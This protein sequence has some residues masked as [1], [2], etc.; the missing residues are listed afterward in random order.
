[1][2]SDRWKKAAGVRG[3]R[4]RHVVLG[5]MFPL[6]FSLALPSA[7]HAQ[8]LI[9][10]LLGDR[11]SNDRFQLG[12]NVGF[13]ATGLQGVQSKFRVGFGVSMYG[14]IRLSDRFRLQPELAMKLPG[15]AREL[16]PG[17]P[18]HSLSPIGEPTYDDVVN[19]GLV[20]RNQKYIGIPIYTKYLIG[21]IGLG[22][23]PQISFLTK[24]TDTSES[25]SDAPKVQLETDAEDDL[26]PVDIGI[27]ASLDYAFSPEHQ[28]RSMRVRAKGYFG[29]VDTVKDNPGD[30]IRNW[31]FQF[32]L[33]IPIGGSSKPAP[34]PVKPAQPV[35]NEPSPPIENESS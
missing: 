3:R 7:A 24:A 22:L 21:P 6:L 18:G 12:L 20:L 34:A 4:P 30:P 16:P 35:T 31:N 28:M 32:G 23:G 5:L 17:A 13:A 8:V 2:N 10:L 27:A 19:N 15:G 29:L 33:D 1:M 14:E 26:S 9:A 25:K 11:V